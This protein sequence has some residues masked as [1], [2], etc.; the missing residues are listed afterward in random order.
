VQKTLKLSEYER[1]MLD[2]EFGSVKQKALEHIA[3]Y[4]KILNASELCVVTKAQLFVGAYPYMDSFPSKDVDEVLSE[5]YLNTDEKNRINCLSCYSQTDAAPFDLQYWQELGISHSQKQKHDQIMQRFKESGITI[6]STCAS[7]LSGFIPLMG[8]HYVST[9]SHALLL[10]N[11]IWGACANADSIETSICS[12]ICGRTPKWGMHVKENRKGTH[13]F[14]LCCDPYSIMDWDLLGF[15]IGKRLPANAIPIITGNFVKPEIDHLKSFFASMATS[16]GVELCLIVGVSPEAMT[17]EQAIGPKTK[18]TPILITRDDLEKERLLLSSP[19]QEKI[20]YISLGCPHYSLAQIQQV[21]QFLRGKKIY[22]ETT[23]H[24]WTAPSIKY[25]AEQ[26]NLVQVIEQAGGLVLTGSC[27]LM[28]EQ[29]KD[30]SVIALDS[31]KQTQYVKSEVQAKFYYGSM[32]NCLRSALTGKW[33]GK[34][35]HSSAKSES[36]IR[37]RGVVD[38]IAEGPALITPESI[39]GWSGLDPETGVITEKGH[40]FEGKSIKGTVLILNGGKGST[41]WATHFHEL[42]VAGIS[43]I[44]FIFPEIDS[45]TAAA[46]AL[47]KIPVVTDIDK[48]IFTLVRTDDILRV[49]GTEG[50]IQ[51][52][53]PN[54]ST[55]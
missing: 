54:H 44:A 47:M 19:G 36:L 45:R 38:G 14:E 43:P 8:E 37:G 7:F 17:L 21:A 49:N 42:R 10:M 48:D 26:S 13:V 28:I 53:K 35:S 15:A 41:G 20:D 12:A 32:E 52:V 3:E 33:E 11:S 50:T 23:L 39:Q 46:A 31:C 6:V 16:G 2:G 9:E 18:K 5:M 27:P 34:E 30:K 55:T 40:P 22:A 1:Q 24:I 29:W 4:A 25:S 51:I